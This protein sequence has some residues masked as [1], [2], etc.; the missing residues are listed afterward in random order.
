MAQ[1]YV[2]EHALNIRGD[3]LAMSNDLTR[4]KPMYENDPERFRQVLT[5]QAALR[6]LPAPC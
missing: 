6:N 1:T 2:R 5:A 3:V 4:L